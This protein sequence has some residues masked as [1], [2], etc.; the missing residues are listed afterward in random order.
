MCKVLKISRTFFYYE[1]RK[2]NTDGN[3]EDTVIRV[4]NESRKV[5][6]TRKIKRELGKL[7]ILASRR[8]IARIMR[9]Y[10][11][12]SCY[13]VKKYRV[14][15]GKPNEDTVLNVVNREFDNRKKLEVVVSDLTYVNVMGK[16]Y[17]I[18]V[19]VDL[20]NREIIG[21]SAGRHKTSDLIYRA[22]SSI[23][24]GLHNINIFHSD[25][26]NEFKNRL[27]DEVIETFNITR[28]LSNKGN[29]YDNAVAEATFKI[30]KTEFVKNKIFKS[31]DDLKFQLMD[32]V[33]W[34]NKKRIHGSLKYL[35]PV[36]Y[37]LALSI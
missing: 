22:L 4:F 25:R 15:P 16:W 12:I 10:G 7:N 2:K 30:I 27:I 36:D 23:K 18:C 31:L 35:S 21:Y 17:Y 8:R 6:G 3:L 13:T 1:S 19:I 26:G 29:P 32:Y 33:N 9:K 37:R 20:F 34:Y 28:S 24:T 5:Y 14:Y 11:L